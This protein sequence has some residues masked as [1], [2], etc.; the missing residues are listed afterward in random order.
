MRCA[1]DPNG[2]AEIGFTDG[3]LARVENNAQFVLTALT[4]Q[5]AVT[6][7][8]TQLLNG[9]SW[10]HVQ[11]LAD[12]GDLYQ[13]DTPVASATVRGTQFAI[14]CTAGTTCTYAVVEGTVQLALP[15]G[16]TLTLTAGQKITLIKDLPPPKIDTPGIP[17]LEQDPWIAQNLALDAPDNPPSTGEGQWVSASVSTE[18]NTDGTT[19]IATSSDGAAWTTQSVLPGKGI[20]GLAWGDERWV[21][22]SSGGSYEGTEV[23]ESTDLHTWNQIGSVDDYLLGLAY[24]D[25][26][27]VAAGVHDNPGPLE[28]SIHHE[29]GVVYTSTDASTWTQVA[30]AGVQDAGGDS[31]AFG[32]GKWLTMSAEDDYSAG[33]GGTP[34][35]K[36]LTS[37]D[38]THWTPSP[39]TVAGAF[40]DRLAFGGGQWVLG[41]ESA[42]G[43]G[44]L[45]VSH[46]TVTWN[47]MSLPG[48]AD[49]TIMAVAYG[50]AQF[51]VA[52]QEYVAGGS[53]TTFFT[54]SDATAWASVGQTDTNVTALAYGG[55]GSSASTPSSPTTTAV[56]VSD[57]PCTTDS[58]AVPFPTPLI[59]FQCK[60]GWAI[61]TTQDE[62]GDEW[63][64][65]FRWDGQAWVVVPDRTSVCPQIPA[66]IH[67]GACEVN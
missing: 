65:L 18:P 6:A 61:A 49:P 47:E 17:Q 35:L 53:S 21:A 67:V 59:G 31:V 19:T 64:P 46:D 7:T 5:D 44:G 25:G 52:N 8:H 14:N 29:T 36:M 26:R 66:P 38:G 60:D 32:D 16:T 3:S 13:V 55:G 40:E 2:F 9:D 42:G 4:H 11:P 24:N 57:A 27:W 20:R 30:T 33:G 43:N 58:L 23:L 50:N 37:S 10:H 12:Q 54:S 28:T 45:R 15:D 34:G 62:N 51:M 48:V 1:T 39:V 56:T 63:I 41:A 22:V